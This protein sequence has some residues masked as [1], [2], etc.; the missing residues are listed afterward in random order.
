[1]KSSK[2]TVSRLV[3]LTLVAFSSAC[4]PA[5]RPEPE[6]EPGPPPQVGSAAPPRDSDARFQLHPYL[7]YTYAPGREG[8][9][10][11]GFEAAGR[12]YPYF[13]A[14]GEFVV[15]VFGGSTALQVARETKA[16]E[17]ALLPSLRSKGYER[18]TV[19][20]FAIEGW[21]QP[22]TFHAFVSYLP[23]IDMALVI[24]GLGEVLEF[25][26]AGR[27]GWPGD[28][29]SATI[30]APLAGVS[31]RPPVKE[32]AVAR[33]ERYFDAW[34]DRI[35]LMDLIGREQKKPMIHFIQPNPYENAAHEADPLGADVTPLYQRLRDLAERLSREGVSSQFLGDA[36]GG[37]EEPVYEGEC[38]RL[39]DD[40]A[41]RMAWAV[42]EEIQ[43]SDEVADM[44]ASAER[45]LPEAGSDVGVPL[46]GSEE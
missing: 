20:P 7:G 14:P 31:A 33:S 4:D 40:G 5:G 6:P 19:L 11:H 24:D 17:N 27:K 12:E 39:N 36:L 1:M 26:D 23:T 42:T 46:L 21:R 38:C 30:Y 35:R 10:R 16:I 8:V 43:F 22:Q 13:R 34:E 41:A 29:P 44:P 15:G 45:D 28:Y 3:L 32:N 37:A 2:A 9:N 25:S 18:V